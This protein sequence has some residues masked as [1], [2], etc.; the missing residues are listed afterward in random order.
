MLKKIYITTAIAYVNG[1]PHI[2][3][4]LEFILA[5]CAARY[6]CLKG[7]EVF[8]VTGTDENSLKNVLAAEKKSVSVKQ[9]VDENSLKFKKLLDIL[10]IKVSDFIR[11]TEQRH[12]EG[13]K[14]FWQAARNDI[15][16]GEYQGLYCVGCEDFVKEE[17]L[18]NGLCPN[19]NSKPELIAEKNYFF[20]L[21]KYQRQL[22]EV[23]QS[24][25]IQIVPG[26][27]KPDVEI[28]LKL[29]LK[30]FSSSRSRERAHNWGIPVPFDDSQVIYVWFDALCNYITVLGYATNSPIYRAWWEDNSTEIWHFIG[31]DISKFHCIYWPAML[32]AA[33]VRL[34]NKI[35][36]HGFITVDGAKMS[37]TLGNFI[38]P[39]DLVNQFGVDAVR[40]YFLREFSLAQDGDLVINNLKERYNKELANGLGNLLNRIVAL[41]EKQ[42]GKI[43]IESN[44]LAEEIKEAWNKYDEAMVEFK[45]NQGAESF[46]QLISKADAF[47]NQTRIWAVEDVEKKNEILSSLWLVLANLADMTYPYLPEKSLRIK[48]SLGIVDKTTNFFGR[49]F[50]VKKLPPLFPRI[51]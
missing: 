21:S 8:F 2:G 7:N 47:I 38:D 26:S 15:Y 36:I 23:Y 6:Q 37:K 39:F 9:L 49:E 34:P 17:D 48:E 12:I 18:I 28:F 46:L 10:N 5:D 41:I 32:L 51:N 25:L 45:F 35:V 29:G 4:T 14:K 13:V 43:R 20:K 44:L 42:D 40:Y 22:E 27:R 19:H 30:D 16:Q 50:T 31:K 3:H 24:N 11:T 1:D 33:S